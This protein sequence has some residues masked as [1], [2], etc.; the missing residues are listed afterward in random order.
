MICMQLAKI[1][2]QFQYIKKYDYVNRC[3]SNSNCNKQMK[4]CPKHGLLSEVRYDY[5]DTIRP[6]QYNPTLSITIRPFQ[7]VPTSSIQ[8]DLLNSIRSFIL[9]SKLWV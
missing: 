2:M 1:F 4:V 3:D 9:I 7:S 8:S 6:F 5:L